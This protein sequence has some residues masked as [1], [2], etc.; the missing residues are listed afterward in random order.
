MLFPCC[1]VSRLLA[2]TLIKCKTY[3]A[4]DEVVAACIQ[5]SNGL[6]TTTYHFRNSRSLS[7]VTQGCH[8]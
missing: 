2:A 4:E 6:E 7:L 8:Q 1:S 5:L 3:Q